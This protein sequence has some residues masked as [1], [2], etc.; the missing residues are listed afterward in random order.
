MDGVFDPELAE[1]EVNDVVLGMDKV[2][3]HTLFA[4]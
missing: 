4:L 2:L 1:V 3:F